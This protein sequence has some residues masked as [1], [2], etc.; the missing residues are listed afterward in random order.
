MDR[1]QLIAIGSIVAILVALMLWLKPFSQS[2]GY[3]DNNANL[4]DGVWYICGDAACSHEWHLTV[5]QLEAHVGAT[6]G[7]PRTQPPCPKCEKTDSIRAEQCKS[8]QKIVRANVGVTCPHCN[9]PIAGPD[10]KGG[11]AGGEKRRE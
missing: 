11:S 10:A 3:G 5:E 4:P 8:C 7:Q 2:E 6:Y 1:Q 9:K